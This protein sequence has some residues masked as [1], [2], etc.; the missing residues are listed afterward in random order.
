MRD[1]TL[2]YGAGLARAQLDRLASGATAT[3]G[4]D[5]EWFRAAFEDMINSGDYLWFNGETG[6]LLST[7][8][9]SKDASW[10]VGLGYQWRG[11]LEGFVPAART[12][13]GWL[14]EAAQ[15]Y[16]ASPTLT[17]TIGGLACCAFRSKP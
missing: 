5:F 10:L 16:W 14:N 6:G 12:R 7:G 3:V 13:G 15:E 1:L 11:G 9:D 2:E 8:R 4:F 17:S